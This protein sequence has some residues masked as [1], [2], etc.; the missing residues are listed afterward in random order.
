MTVNLEELYTPKAVQCVQCE[1]DIDPIVGRTEKLT[2]GRIGYYFCCDNCDKKYPFAAITEE[3]QKILKQ[4]KRTR[5]DM[6]QFP[7]IRKNLVFKL[8]KQ[9]KEYEKEFEGS[10]TEEDVL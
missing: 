4:I 2:K 8:K 5:K 7:G 1:Q 9:Q 10:Y 6:K 3:G